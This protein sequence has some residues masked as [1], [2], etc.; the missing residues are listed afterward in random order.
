MRKSR[1]ELEVI[2]RRIIEKHRATP[3]KYDDMLLMLMGAQ[4]ES[5]V[6]YMSEELLTDLRLVT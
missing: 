5:A 2:L 1:A 6:R 4:D 3:E